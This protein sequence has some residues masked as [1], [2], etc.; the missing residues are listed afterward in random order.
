[1]TNHAQSV[2]INFLNLTY[3]SCGKIWIDEDEYRFIKVLDKKLP[4]HGWCP[5]IPTKSAAA[6][7]CKRGA[8][9]TT[10]IEWK[11]FSQIVG[12]KTSYN[13]VGRCIYI[14]KERKK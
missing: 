13:D 7:S 8:G 2:E 9:V 10:H 1:M 5:A 4:H 14:R 11:N 3:L 12:V 6:W